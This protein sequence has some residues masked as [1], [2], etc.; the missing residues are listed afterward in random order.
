AAA[1]DRNPLGEQARAQGLSIGEIAVV[2]EGE[3]PQGTL[4][5][6]GLSIFNLAGAGRRVAGMADSEVSRQLSEIFFSKSLGNPTHLPME[7]KGCT[8]IAGSN[9]RALLTAVLQGVE[10]KVGYACDI[11]SRR[12]YPEHPTSLSWSVRNISPELALVL[13]HRHHLFIGAYAAGSDL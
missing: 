2:S 3:F 6:K 1:G 8:T 11:L 5:Y 7:V 10:H 9:A 4:H 12:V 13:G